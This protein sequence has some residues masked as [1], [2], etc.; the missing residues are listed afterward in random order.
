MAESVESLCVRARQAIAQGQIEQARQLYLQALGLK[1]DAPDVHYGLATACFLV[2]DLDSAAYHFKEVT[3]LDP[4]RPG[5]YINLGA[6][7]NR[8]GEYEEAVQTLRRGIQL[9][10]HRGEGY[11]NL[12]LVYKNMGQ[13]NLAVQAYLEATR[14]D[15]RM[16]DAHYNLGNLYLE[17]GRYKQ[18]IA[19][20][21]LALQLRPH[22]DKAMNGLAQADAAVSALEPAKPAGEAKVSEPNTAAEDELNRNVDPDAHGDILTVLHHAAIDS[23]AHGRQFLQILEHQIEPAIKDLSTRLLGVETSGPDLNQC[24]QMFESAVDNMRKA[25][26]ELESSVQRVRTLGDQLL[27]S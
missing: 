4:L 1:S 3:R 17:T 25:Q 21:K 10:P 8:L 15:S 23:E 26:E 2:N 11:Y 27:K 13:P 18:A 5:A 19:H 20:Y 12:G 7:Y 22:W 16:V 6:V 14:V 24:I 9:D